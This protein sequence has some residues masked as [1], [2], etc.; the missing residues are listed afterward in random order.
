MS[1]SGKAFGLSN[2]IDF[3]KG[4][5]VASNGSFFSYELRG[6]SKVEW[7]AKEPF[8]LTRIEPPTTTLEDKD[9]ISLMLQRITNVSTV[10]D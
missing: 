6:V 7:K 10:C 3:A 4:I 9:N 5:V 1:G 8:E 2:S